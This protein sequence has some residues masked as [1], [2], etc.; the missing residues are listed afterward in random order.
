M[1]ITAANI[2]RNPVG[3]SAAVVG[4]QSDVDRKNFHRLRA[5]GKEIRAKVEKM[6]FHGGKAVDMRDSAKKKGGRWCASRAELLREH[7]RGDVVARFM[8]QIER[9]AAEAPK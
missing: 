8:E 6:N 2:H 5:I 4:I 9:D 1:T 3:G 7:G